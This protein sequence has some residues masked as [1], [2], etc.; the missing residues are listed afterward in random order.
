LKRARVSVIMLIL[1]LASM[2]TFAFSIQPVKASGTI[3]IRADGSIDPSTAPIMRDGDT[4]TF[5]NNIFDS[6]VVERN[7][8]LLDGAGY[9]LQGTGDTD[10]RGIDLSGRT[11]VS[12]KNIQIENFWHGVFLYSSFSNSVS[13]NNIT[14]SWDGIALTF[15]FGTNISGNVISESG[16]YGIWVWGSDNSNIVRNSA[17]ANYAGIALDSSSSNDI[18]GNIITANDWTGISLETSTSNSVS[19]NVVTNNGYG[20]IVWESSS[21][22]TVS[23]NSFANNECGIRLE[24]AA[25][26]SFYHNCFTDNYAQFSVSFGYPNVWDDGYPSGG[27]YWSDYVARYPSAQEL[28]DSGIWDTPYVLDEN[29]KDN[30]PLMEPWTSLDIDPDTLNLKIKEKWITAYIQ[31]PE[32]YNA[33]DIDASTILLNGVIAPVLDSKYG[34]VT[35]SREYLVDHDGDGILERMVKFDRASLASWICQSVKMRHEVTLAI[36]GEL[37]DGTLFA[38]TATIFVF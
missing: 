22:N 7:Y 20:I 9:K 36:T 19:G 31:L 16:D 6:I 32:G 2:F 8:I 5:T 38:A 18:S 29:N 3:Y 23:G 30:Y 10:S 14:N 33:A 25:D 4:Y 11:N 27:N 13:D 12:V 15:S 26:N 17:S 21:Y 37:T 35:N 28:D 34:F 24:V 1:L